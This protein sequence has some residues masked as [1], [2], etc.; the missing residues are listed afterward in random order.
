MSTNATKNDVVQEVDL[1]SLS[2]GIGNAFRSLNDLI[3]R[4][5]RF[6]LRNIIWIVALIVIGGGLGYWLDSKNRG[7]YKTQLIFDTN[8][9]STDYLYAK[10]EQLG[11][12]IKERDTV[13]LS[14]VVGIKHPEDLQEIGIS[15]VIDVFKFVSNAGNEAN[16]RLIELMAQDGDIKKIVADNTTSKN[17]P[18]HMI[19][20]KTNG[21]TTAERTVTPLLNYLNDNDYYKKVQQEYLKNVDVKLRA[22]DTMVK[23]IDRLLK[24]YANESGATGQSVYINENTQLN[25]MIKTKD[26]MIRDQGVNRVELVGLDKVIKDNSIITNIKDESGLG[27]KMKLVLPLLFIFIF[28]CVA[29]IKTLYQN[30]AAKYNTAK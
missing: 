15:P 30:Q 17:Y 19:S 6:L 18:Y 22:N 4:F 3:Y 5:I 25:D 23:Q 27:G 26:Q 10:V 9:G 24:E 11:G 21:R 13:F 20:F 16:Y 29:A 14:K 28:L 2:K 1:M 8:F 7:S 12:K